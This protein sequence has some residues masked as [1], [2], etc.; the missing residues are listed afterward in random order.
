MD[1]GGPATPLGNVYASYFCG[2][3]GNLYNITGSSVGISD[4]D[5]P[6]YTGNIGYPL[7]PA[8]TIYATSFVGDGGNLTSLPVPDLSGYTG[9]IG[10]SDFNLPNI[11][12]LNACFGQL[13][14][15]GNVSISA[16]ASLPSPA[17]VGT[18]CYSRHAGGHFYGM[19]DDG[20]KQLDS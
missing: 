11:F 4:L 14:V 10:T 16:G 19:T 6:A 12:A 3:G 15:D 18:I 9:N 2:D 20:W 17:S 7:Y 5:L 13:E 1:L 8:G